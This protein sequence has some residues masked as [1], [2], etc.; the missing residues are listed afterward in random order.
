MEVHGVL[1]VIDEIHRNRLTT[2]ST[3]L[4]ALRVFST[5]QT[6]RLPRREVAA[7]IKRY[8]ALK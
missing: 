4:A 1:W 3:L 2:A 8:A 6:V 7:F 5:D